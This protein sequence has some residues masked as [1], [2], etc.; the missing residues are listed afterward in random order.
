MWPL[1]DHGLADRLHRV[2][3]EVVLIW[4]SEDRIV[5]PSYGERFAGLLPAATV[6][7]PIAGAAHL[8]A[9]D[10]PAAVAAIVRNDS[11]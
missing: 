2:A 7:P 4:G 9:L 1:P 6:A 11:G 8:V 3:A 10:A 5:P